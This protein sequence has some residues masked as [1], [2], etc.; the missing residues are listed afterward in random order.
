MFKIQI[1]TEPCQLFHP[2]WSRC[3]CGSTV[4]KQ[5]VRSAT[6]SVVGSPDFPGGALNAN[7]AGQEDQNR[8]CRL[9]FH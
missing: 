7:R 2:Q 6:E 5:P 4:P 1:L 3:R 9:L 8:H